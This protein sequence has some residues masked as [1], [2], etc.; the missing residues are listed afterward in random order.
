MYVP[1]TSYIVYI[2]VYTC[3]DMCIHACYIYP[4]ARCVCH[5]QDSLV[6]ELRRSEFQ[7]FTGKFSGLWAENQSPHFFGHK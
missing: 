6:A 1:G 2:H 3:Y 4:P 5:G 7:Y